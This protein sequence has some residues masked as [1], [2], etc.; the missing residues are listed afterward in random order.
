MPEPSF[1]MYEIMVQS[2]GAQS[3]KIP[4]KDL[5]VDLR[6]MEASITPA[7]RMVFVNNPNNP[8]GTVVSRNDFDAFLKNVPPEVIVIMDEAYIEFVRD[9]NNPQGLE[10]LKSDHLVVTLRTFSKAY[11]LAGLRIGYGVMKKELAGFVNRVRQ[12]FN[13]NTLAQVGALA[14]LNDETFFKKT[15][16]MVH[17]ELDM[18]YDEVRNL[19]LTFFPSEANFF[20]L[21]V[22]QDARDVFQ[23]LLKKGVIVRAMTAYG[24]PHYLRVNVGLPKENRRFIKALGEVLQ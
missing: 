13:T 10:Y 20:L 6:K 7:T 22:K 3:V 12:P 24:Y 21:D 4:L 2:V 16:S 17:Q 14:A 1:L 18:L 19:G 11:G 9:D 15:I 8:T 5:G 23:R